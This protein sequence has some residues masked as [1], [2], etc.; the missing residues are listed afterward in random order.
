MGRAVWSCPRCQRTFAHRNQTH[1]CAP[2][3]ELDRHFDGTQPAVRE[4]FDRIVAL[5]SAIGPV[6]I[7]PERSRIAL[8]VRMSFAAFQPRRR[9]LDGQLVLA[10]ELTA[11]GFGGWRPS[12]R[13]TS[14]TRFGDVSDRDRRRIRGLA[15]GG[16]S[17]R[18]SAPPGTT[19]RCPAGHGRLVTLVGDGRLAAPPAV[20]DVRPR[21]L[22]QRESEPPRRG[23]FPLRLAIR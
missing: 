16:V 12:R 3:G 11:R 22:P 20:P 1:T 15:G 21:R 17:G 14:C 23:P 13:G 18:R 9:W 5:I 7:L 4:T 2:L 10:G 19:A 6:S 8:H